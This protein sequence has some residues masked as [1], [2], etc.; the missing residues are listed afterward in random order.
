[1]C[2][3]FLCFC[4]FPIWC[5]GKVYYLIVSIPDICHLLYFYST[6]IQSE[7]V[8]IH[9]DHFYSICDCC[10]GPSSAEVDLEPTCPGELNISY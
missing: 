4:H 2:D 8:S 5:L 10:S 6:Q 9:F 7:M 1:M 3:V